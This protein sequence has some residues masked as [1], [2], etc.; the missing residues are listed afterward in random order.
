MCVRHLQDPRERALA[1]FF[2]RAFSFFMPELSVPAIYF[3]PLLIL[4]AA[5]PGSGIIFLQLVR[6]NY[7][8]R[9]ESTRKITSVF[10]S[11][12]GGNV[13]FGEEPSSP[14]F[15]GGEFVV[16]DEIMVARK[17]VLMYDIVKCIIFG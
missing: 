2:I 15:F 12:Y 6:F 5:R 7:A 8:P 4:R 17:G 10:I 1:F 9:K 16:E 13:C 3:L 14:L 11:D